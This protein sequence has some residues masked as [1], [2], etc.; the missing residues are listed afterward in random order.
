MCTR[1]C[2]RA[3]T[4][5]CKACPGALDSVGRGRGEHHAGVGGVAGGAVSEG[6]GHAGHQGAVILGVQGLDAGLGALVTIP[7]RLCVPGREV[8]RDHP[9]DVILRGLARVA[10]VP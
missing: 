10:G 5:S 6:G 3:C 4:R 7:G 2:T 1:A 8:H 9:V